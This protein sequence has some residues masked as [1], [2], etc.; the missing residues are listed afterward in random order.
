MAFA[1][2]WMGLGMLILSE[3]SQKEKDKRIV[4]M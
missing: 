2:T 3:V 1:A 4:Y